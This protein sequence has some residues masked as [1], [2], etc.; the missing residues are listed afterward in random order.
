M[1]SPTVGRV[2]WF[3]CFGYREGFTNQPDN[4]PCAAIVVRV[5][6]DRLV[7]LVVFDAIGRSF[8]FSSVT[9]VQ[10]GDSIPEF[11]YYATWMPYQVGQAKK[12]ANEMAIAYTDKPSGV[13]G[14]G[15]GAGKTES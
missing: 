1:I 15:A 9:L 10:E 4:Q 11:G 13:F 2:L 12:H 5:W 3:Y 6:D 7:N 8:P 14:A